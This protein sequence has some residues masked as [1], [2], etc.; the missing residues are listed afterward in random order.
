MANVAPL[1]TRLQ[2]GFGGNRALA[3]RGGDRV[4][5]YGGEEFAILLPQTGALGAQLLA[6]LFVVVLVDLLLQPLMMRRLL[7]IKPETSAP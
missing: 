6:L 4:Y 1:A 7:P 2:R 5:R 3:G